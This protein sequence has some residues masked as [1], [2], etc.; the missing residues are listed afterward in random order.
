[1]CSD[2]ANEMTCFLCHKIDVRLD[3]NEKKYSN[4][5]SSECFI[6]ISL[7]LVSSL[8]YC[9]LPTAK[10]RYRNYSSSYMFM[11]GEVCSTTFK[12]L[13]N[14]IMQHILTSKQLYA[15]LL[16]VSALTKC[17]RT[18]MSSSSGA[19]SVG[20]QLEPHSPRQGRQCWCWNNMT[21]QEAAATPT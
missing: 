7:W 21:R 14:P 6:L 20:W 12:L 19:V 11:T 18:W 5:N 9:L 2:T 4:Y 17:P 1:M 16:Q 10:H 8:I 13:C 15:F 3:L